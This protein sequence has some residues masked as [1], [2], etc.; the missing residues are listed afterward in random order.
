MIKGEKIRFDVHNILYSI[1]KLNKNLKDPYIKKI[2]ATHKKE[3][4]SFINNVALNS[5]RYSIHVDRIIK[6]FA[7]K[8]VGD[9]ERILFVSAITQIVFLEFRE[10]AVINCSVEIAK[11]LKIYHGFVNAFLKNISI[12]KDR[13]KNTTIKFNDLPNWFKKE[14][15][16]LSLLEKKKFIENFNKEPDIHLVFKNNKSLKEFDE[17]IFETSDSSGF[18]LIKKDVKEIKSFIKGNWWVQDYSSFFPINNLPIKNTSKKFLDVCAAPGGKAF[19]ILSK[20]FDIVLNDKSFERIKILKSNLNRLNFN[21]K[22]LNQDFTKFEDNNK[23]DCIII[24][25][26][27]SSIGTIRRNPE[28]FFKNKK[29]DFLALNIIQKSMLEKASLLLNKHGIILYMVCSFLK[30]ETRDQI[31]S[32]LKTRN[33]FK[34]YDFTLKNKDKENSKL[35]KNNVMITL[36]DTIYNHKIDGYFAAYLEKIR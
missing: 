12:N 34:L 3:D 1:F 15:K 36:P 25:A 17:K 31:N 20:K 6:E 28:I 8:K 23:Y 21:V 5:M 35:I 7:L 13:L 18:L 33:N 16:S 22:I 29:P 10:Y 32:F 30:R 9:H 27:C 4:I 14:T 2:V 19:Q 24:D 26:P 11:K